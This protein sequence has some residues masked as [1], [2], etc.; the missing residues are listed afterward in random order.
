MSAPGRKQDLDDRLVGEVMQFVHDP[1]GFVLFAF[2]WGKG[3]LEGEYPDQWQIDLLEDIR[4]NLE[5]D[6]LGVQQLARSSGHGIGKTALV[7]WVILWAMSTRPHLAGVVTANTQTQLKTKTWREL[8][9]WHARTINRHWFE[10]RATKFFHVDHE[11]TWCVDAIPWSEHN[12][13]AFAG[14][15]AKHVLMIFDEASAVADKIWEVSDGAMT[16]ERAMWLVFGN[17]TRNTGRFRE[18]FGRYAHRWQGKRIDARTCKMTNKAKLNEWVSDHGEDSDF[19]RVRVRG[20]FPR[21][22]TNQLISSEAVDN[23]RKADIGVDEYVHFNVLIGVDVGRFGSDETVIT[24]RQGRRVHEQRI[25]RGL[26]NIQ[27]GARAAEVWRETGSKGV[28]FVDGIGLG[29]GVVDYLMTAGYPVI[30]VVGG[31]K[32]NDDKRFYNKRAEM[33]HRM[34]EWIARGADIPDDSMLCDQMTAL[35][36]GYDMRER[37]KLETKEQ[38]ADRMPEL[39]SP[40]R[41]DSLAMT[42]AEIIAPGGMEGSFEPEEE[43]YA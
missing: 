7:A 30:D 21:F 15:H 3:E 4:L 11:T 34:S 28:I 24:V 29:T 14:L 25:Y 16:T 10:W 27:V 31:E 22:G 38:L 39:G 41:A 6:P 33:W 12:A 9:V 18:C 19:V 8:S 13:E 1:L 23:A 32:A 2:D 36:Y 35:E 26:N 43:E 37:I 20:E 5:E 17:P 42:F 40:D